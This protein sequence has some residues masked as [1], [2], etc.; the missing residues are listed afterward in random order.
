MLCILIAC[1]SYY[2]SIRE[3]HIHTHA[4]IWRMRSTAML[5][6]W[7]VSM[8]HTS[9]QLS[10][11][12]WT[13]II[14]AAVQKIPKIC[15]YSCTQVDAKCELTLIPEAHVDMMIKQY[16]IF[17]TFS[18]CTLIRLKCFPSQATCCGQSASNSRCP[19]AHTYTHCLHATIFTVV[20]IHSSLHSHNLWCIN[21]ISSL[22][23]LQHPHWPVAVSV[24]RWSGLC[25]GSL[26]LRWN[27]ASHLYGKAF[28]FLLVQCVGFRSIVRYNLST[29]PHLNQ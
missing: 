14:F 9:L 2:A 24:H 3:Q 4:P 15:K 12:N 6:C 22:T 1:C 28:S 29:C 13:Q 10:M 23:L 19:H 8:L 11:L 5:S 27:A 17:F 7:A 21:S 18:G 16:M 26:F 20:I 25:E